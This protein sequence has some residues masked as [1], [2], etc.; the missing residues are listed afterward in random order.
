MDNTS[1]KAPAVVGVVVGR[2]SRYTGNRALCVTAEGL[3]ITMEAY[4]AMVKASGEVTRDEE[5]R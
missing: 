3:V 1:K 5:S 4:K 2:K